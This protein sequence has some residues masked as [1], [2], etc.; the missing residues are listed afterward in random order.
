ML[1]K[2]VVSNTNASPGI[3]ER[4]TRGAPDWVLD[5]LFE[6]AQNAQGPQREEVLRTL[7]G[8]VASRADRAEYETNVLRELT[9]IR[10]HLE[11]VGSLLMLQIQGQGYSVEKETEG[12]V[13]EA[14][15]ATN[16]VDPRRDI[17]R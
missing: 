1:I 6:Y 7:A 8:I 9:L 16:A 3:L 14:G 11:F 12:S 4:L 10:Q 2:E 15:S 5:K 17:Y 13:T